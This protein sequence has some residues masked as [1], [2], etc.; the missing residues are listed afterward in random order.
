MAEGQP[1]P[2]TSCTS[3]NYESLHEGPSWTEGDAGQVVVGGQQVRARRWGRTSHRRHR[4][5]SESW[6]GHA[7]QNSH[8]GGKSGLRVMR[9]VKGLVTKS[10]LGVRAQPRQR[11]A[12]T[13][14]GPSCSWLSAQGREGP[15]IREAQRCR[16]WGP[17]FGSQ[18]SL[19]TSFQVNHR[20]AVQ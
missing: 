10:G 14:P 2:Q 16:L 19:K 11:Q 12:G 20:L 17:S 15:R 7:G 8:A 9:D 5:S 13:E 1:G 6:N 3:S 18:R 4:Q